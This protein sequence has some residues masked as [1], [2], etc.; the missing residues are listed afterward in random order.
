MPSAVNYQIRKLEQQLGV[1]LVLDDAVGTGADRRQVGGRLAAL[2]AGVV[3][4]H[5]LG[6][7]RARR[8]DEGVGPERRR[9]R[10]LHDHR[11]LVDLLD[12]DVLVGAAGHRRRRGIARIIP[13][14]D[15][16]VGGERPAV[17]PG[18]AGLDFPDH[19]LA[20]GGER[21]VFAARDRSGETGPE[22]AIAVPARQRLV[23]DA[24]AVLVLGAGGEVWIEE[25]GA[26]PPQHLQ[27]TAAPA[28][29]RLV[30]R[31]RLRHC[32][33][34]IRQQLGGQRRRQASRDHSLHEGAARQRARLCLADQSTQ[35]AFFHRMPP[36]QR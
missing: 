18:D 14:E 1:R 7:D 32:H 23:E 10:E 29:G 16:V 6:Q 25:R 36:T 34:G 13:G 35:F 3:A 8:A 15:H 30:D 12:H 4:E 11:V 5:V 9:P 21:A 28:L 33:A 31:R 2:R 19:R 20:V 24:A 27:E 26:L 22:I 17:V